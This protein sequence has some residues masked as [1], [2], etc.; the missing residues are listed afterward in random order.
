MSD[1][2][3]CT[4]GLCED[5]ANPFANLSAEAPDPDIFIGYYHGNPQ[6]PP[7]IN[8]LWGTPGCLSACLS[9]VSQEE[10]DLCAAR[11]QFLCTTQDCETADCAGGGGD[12]GWR[13]PTGPNAYGT[14]PPPTANSA[15]SCASTC[16]DGLSFTYTV[17]AGT[18]LS[19]SQATSNAI[20]NSLACNS[21]AVRKLCLSTPAA[22]A[23]LGAA[24]TSSIEVTGGTPPFLWT[25]LAGMLPP[26][27]S[28]TE[29]ED[30][31]AQLIT[32]TP[33]ASGDYSFTLQVTDGAGAFMVKTFHISVIEITN[34]PPA[35]QTG[36]VYSFAFT[37]NG[38]TPP[39]TFALASGSL[40]AGLSLSAAGGITGVPTT[41]ETANFTVSVTDSS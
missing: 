12:G 29:Q 13:P 14:N 19:L 9:S 11:Q 4:K 20:A 32:G 40:P 15:Q 17:P 5:P 31:F 3:C 24:Y 21:A 10:A 33:T 38:G 39:Y 27:L 1:I 26:G 36:Q 16:P 2:L 23:C 7:R 28:I 34:S 25:E 22:S 8:W 6:E 18:V 41:A 37:V 30:T 35:G